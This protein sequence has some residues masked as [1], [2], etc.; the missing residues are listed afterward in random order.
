MAALLCGYVGLWLI[1]T[2]YAGLMHDAQAYALQALARLD[3]AGLGRDLFLRFGSQDDFSIFSRLYAALLHTFGLE[4][5]AAIATFAA[6]VGWYGAACLL[7]RRL[8]GGRTALLAL[9]LLI[10]I[11]GIYG[12]QRVFHFAEP[13]MTARLPAE[14]LVLVALWA[15]Q[16]SYR[17]SCMLLLAC[18][19]LIHPLIAL[20]GLLVT[21]MLAADKARPVS[22]T[23]PVL[24]VLVVAG[25]MIGA[26]VLRGDAPLMKGDWFAAVRTRSSFL[27]LDRW[28]P[29]DWGALAV[30]IATL[31]AAAMRLGDSAR[32]FARACLWVGLAGLALTAIAAQLWHLTL[33]LQGQPW[34]W[35]W[36]A[37]FAAIVCLAPIALSAWR[38]DGAQRAGAALLIAAWLATAPAAAPI[39]GWIPGGLAAVSVALLWRSASLPSSTTRLLKLGALLVLGFVVAA[40]IA[41]A[42]PGPR[43]LATLGPRGALASAF[44]STVPAFIAVVVMGWLT[45]SDG[46]LPRR[47]GSWIFC[48]TML[49]GGLLLGA[50]NWTTRQFGPEQR[51]LFADWRE[52]IPAEAEVFWWDGVRETWFLLDRRSYLSLSQSGGVIFSAPLTMELR[53]RAAVAQ[54]FVDPGHWFNAPR[55]ADVRAAPLDIGMMAELCR[56]PALGFVVSRDRLREDESAVLWPIRGDR[57]VYLHDCAS[58]RMAAP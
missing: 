52:R 36:L 12:G 9:G 24:A 39:A 44:G 33:L 23:M 19:M 37:R 26:T 32:A 8:L 30:T 7:C 28:Q 45:L 42:W 3:P 10:A 22:S 2:P 34:R 56:D 53:R 11:P 18:A 40:G 57:N 46:R 50:T 31:V 29:A 13:F 27:F 17:L 43:Q 20:P 4:R 1:V 5:G 16:A 41:W 38:A 21:A 15:W 49:L 25:A 48:T 51:E 14:V 58:W 35:L 55:S 6:H 54:R 47:I